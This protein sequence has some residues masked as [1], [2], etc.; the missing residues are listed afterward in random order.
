MLSII[1][2]IV[3]LK[4][5]HEEYK[6]IVNFQPPE[7]RRKGT[8]FSNNSDHS[9]NEDKKDSATNLVNNQPIN[10]PFKQ[11]WVWVG[12]NVASQSVN[13]IQSGLLLNAVPPPCL[14]IKHSAASSNILSLFFVLMTMYMGYGATLWYIFY[15]K[16]LHVKTTGVDRTVLYSD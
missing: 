2:V 14:I 10:N 4:T 12:I 11:L 1:V 5:Q 8:C 16:V 15:V 3:M 7:P 6:K 9:D 13:L